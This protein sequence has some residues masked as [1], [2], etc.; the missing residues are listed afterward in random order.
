MGNHKLAVRQCPGFQPVGDAFF[1]LALTEVEGRGEGASNSGPGLQYS[2]R[3]TLASGPVALHLTRRK[4]S[5]NPAAPLRLDPMRAVGPEEPYSAGKTSLFSPADPYPLRKTPSFG[6][7]D[8]ILPTKS[9]PSA[10]KTRH[11][12]KFDPFGLWPL[13]FGPPFQPDSAQISPAPR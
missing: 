12:R 1:S 2:I 9:P 6:P 7:A 10:L 8:P 5:D 11:L 4:P 3:Q 13:D